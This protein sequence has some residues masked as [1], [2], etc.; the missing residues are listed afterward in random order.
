VNTSPHSR[1]IS[2]AEFA[3]GA[4]IVVGHN[5]FRFLPNEVPILFVLALV[6]FRVREGNWRAMGVARPEAWKR[7]L[8]IAVGAAALRLVLG[9]FVVEPLAARVWPPMV[10]P[11]GSE[12]IAGNWRVTLEWLALV[13]TFAAVGEEVGYRGYLLTRAAQAL[14]GARAAWW[15][16]VVLS[17]VLFGYGHSYKGPAGIADSAVAGLVLGTVYLMARRNLWACVIAHGLIDT[18]GVAA[19]FLGINS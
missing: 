11:S 2:A 10:A 13:W 19:A 9:Q 6:S 16:A 18:V 12:S 3:V 7:V 14:G 5:V 15:A 8:L 4:A 1:W 17:A